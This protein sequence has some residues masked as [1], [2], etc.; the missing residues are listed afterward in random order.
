MNSVTVVFITG[1]ES[2]NIL[3]FINTAILISKKIA[4]TNKRDFF[5]FKKVY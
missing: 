3:N 4:V 1:S 5:K 2:I